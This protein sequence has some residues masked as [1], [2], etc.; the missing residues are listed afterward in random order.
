MRGFLTKLCRQ[1]AEVMQKQEKLNFG[2]MRGDE[3]PYKCHQWLEHGG[4]EACELSSD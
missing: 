4:G 1:Q 2:N 3:D